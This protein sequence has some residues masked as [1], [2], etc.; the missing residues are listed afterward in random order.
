M[1]NYRWVHYYNIRKQAIDKARAGKLAAGFRMAKK[2]NQGVNSFRGKSKF[3]RQ[4]LEGGGGVGGWSVVF[5]QELGRYRGQ[6]KQVRCPKPGRCTEPGGGVGC[7][8]GKSCS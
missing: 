1:F 4:V 7:N 3:V 2:R 6:N 5:K 8:R